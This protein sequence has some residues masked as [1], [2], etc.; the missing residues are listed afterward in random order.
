M[1]TQAWGWLTA[2]VLAAGLNSSYHNGGLQWAHE[3]ADRVQHNSSAVFALATGRADQFLAE[4]RMLNLDRAVNS[5][6]DRIDV[7][8]NQASHCPFSAAVAHIQRNFDHSQAQFDRFQALSTRQQA[9]L[10]RLEANRARIAAQVQAEMARMQF[11]DNRFRV[12]ENFSFANADVS[13][14]VLDL[15]RI[16]CPR[17]RVTTPRVHVRVP[18]VE[19]PSP[20]VQVDD[21][22]QGPI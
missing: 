14:V 19:I 16:H 6:A 1:K 11:A 4:A 10:A 17:V 12:N 8:D 20:V 7:A 3:I 9:K 18:K 21:S 2:A 15:P 22:D 13:P 5:A